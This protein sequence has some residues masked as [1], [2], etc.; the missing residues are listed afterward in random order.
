MTTNDTAGMVKWK[1]KDTMDMHGITR[2]ALQKETGAAM[3]TLRAMYDGTTRRPD[4]DVLDGV[5]RALRKATGKPLGLS[6]VLE[7]EE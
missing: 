4:L 7:W 6:D 5:I 1:L 2:Y 3:N